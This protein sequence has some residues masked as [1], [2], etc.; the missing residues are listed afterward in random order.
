[1]PKDASSF[2]NASFHPPCNDCP[3][4]PVVLPQSVQSIVSLVF[5]TDYPA[6]DAFFINLLNPSSW[7]MLSWI[8]IVLF[9][10]KSIRFSSLHS[11]LSFYHS[12]R[13]TAAVFLYVFCCHQYL[14]YALQQRCSSHNRHIAILW[15]HQWRDPRIFA[16]SQIHEAID[17]KIPQ[18]GTHLISTPNSL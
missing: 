16:V 11:V 4:V 1:M 6:M 9:S 3:S 15:W 14:L 12:F 18:R 2:W 10:L 17:P 8:G 7:Y 13:S 5:L